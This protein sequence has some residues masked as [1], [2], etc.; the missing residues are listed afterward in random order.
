MLT[1]EWVPGLTLSAD[2]YS[3]NIHG[4]IDTVD[5][6]TIIDRCL[7]GEAVYCP[8][9]VFAGGAAQPNQINVSPLN[10]ALDSISGLDLAVR[11]S[12]ALGAGNVTW[13][14]LATY[15]A[16]Q[17]RTAQGI[18]YDRA[19]A[20][21]LSPDNYAAGSPKLRATLAGTYMEGPLSFTTQLRLVGPA[22]LSNG[23]QGQARILPASLSAGG[24]LTRGAIKGLVDDND[25]AA[26][27][28]LDLRASWR[29]SEALTFYGA[30][31][32]LN[33]EAPPTIASTGGGNLPNTQAYDGLGRV[34][35]IGVR[36]VH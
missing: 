18:T 27:T 19:G 23:I 6:Q 25:I 35:R 24:V 9:L 14:L 33:N 17:T 36:L 20:L 28:Y 15:I 16:Q 13:D 26:R 21:G 7:A 34:F 3:V 29:W 32:N 31:D 22:V 12:H 4:A 1:P 5:F 2:W 8:Q 30:V 10:S 11:Y